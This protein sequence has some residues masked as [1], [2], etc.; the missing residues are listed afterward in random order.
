[1]REGGNGFG[2]GFP[3]P[4]NFD[5]KPHGPQTPCKQPAFLMRS[6]VKGCFA[7][8]P[9]RHSPG[10]LFFIKLSEA[11]FLFVPLRTKTI[12]CDCSPDR[13]FR[14][15]ARSDQSLSAIRILRDNEGAGQ[16]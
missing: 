4:G 12:R 15:V 3:G 11:L 2:T 6:P 8:S 9:R 5:Q 10:V 1:M 13:H 14:I 16:I 7:N